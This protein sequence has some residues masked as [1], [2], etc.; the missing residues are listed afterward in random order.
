MATVPLLTIDH[1][2]SGKK[3]EVFL[4][5]NA[6]TAFDFPLFL[7]PG[8][9]QG[10]VASFEVQLAASDATESSAAVLAIGAAEKLLKV[11][12]PSSGVVT[13]LTEDRARELAGAADASFGQLFSSSVTER[14][15]FDLKI[16]HG[17]EYRITIYAP[18]KEGGWNADPSA[19]PELIG[20]WDV[21]LANARPSLFSLAEF[22]SDVTQ[23]RP[24]LSAGTTDNPCHKALRDGLARPFAILSFKLYDGVNEVGSISSFLRQQTWWTSMLPVPAIIS[25][26]ASASGVTVLSETPQT[27]GAAAGR[28]KADDP[29]IIAFCRKIRSAMVEIGLNGLDSR[30]VTYAVGTSPMV[31]P[32]IG[33]AMGESAECKAS[34]GDL[35]TF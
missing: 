27:S 16:R 5:A 4:R 9:A 31:D 8:D 15:R 18:R 22:E 19:V 26:P 24:C 6:R 13:K 21:K 7:A 3:G 25:S 17:G 12:A 20:T 10:D 32:A 33:K 14:Q 28:I 11:M 1:E 29:K 34:P 2:S 35:D 30:L 23:D